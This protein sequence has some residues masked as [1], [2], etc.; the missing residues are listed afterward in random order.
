MKYI[1]LISLLIFVSSCGG[2]GGSSS[3][4]IAPS[5]GTPSEVPVVPDSTTFPGADWEVYAP[6]EVGISQA[7]IDAALDYAFIEDRFTQGVVI[8]RH[9]VIV[10]ERYAVGKSADTLATSWSTGKSFAS[11]L[12]GIAV[13]QGDISSIDDPAENYLPEWVNTDREAITV[14]ALLEMRSGLGLA[15]ANVADTEMYVEGGIGGD[16]L[17]YAL[18]RTPETTPRTNNWVYQ[19]T[20]SMLL[21][22]IIENATG[23]NVLNYA[24]LNLFSKIGMEATWWTDEAGHALTYCCIDA[25]SR[26]FARFGLLIARDGKWADTQVVSKDWVDKATAVSVNL[27]SDASYGLQWWINSDLGYFYAAGF[28]KNHIYIFPQHDLVIVRNSNYTRT[29]T[30]TVRTGSNAHR[31]DGPNQWSDADFVTLVTAGIN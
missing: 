22:G 24:D 1:T 2:G 14:R 21:S 10:G 12:I 3:P 5:A 8:I 29:G 23:Q 28:H 6:D 17:A 9:G 19:N 27:S 11:T 31:T 26:D 30:D 4:D 18:N 7:S 16:Q 13:D 20:D 25:T 15:S